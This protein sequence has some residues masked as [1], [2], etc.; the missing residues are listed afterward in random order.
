[1]AD[2]ACCACSRTPSADRDSCGG[3]TEEPLTAGNDRSAFSAA[4][5]AAAGDEPP[6]ANRVAEVR[7]ALPSEGKQQMGR[8]D[9]GMTGCGG[10]TDSI[11]ERL[12]GLGGELKF[13]RCPDC[14]AGFPRSTRHKVERIPLNFELDNGQALLGRT[15]SR[16]PVCGSNSLPWQLQIKRAVVG[17]LAHR[18]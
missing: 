11:G 5:A 12:L 9:V 10:L 2:I 16:A 3:E 14:G 8:L 7:V 18:R 13:H 6:A 4:W 15:S 17:Q 1:M